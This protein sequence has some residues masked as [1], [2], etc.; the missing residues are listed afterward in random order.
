MSPS[1]RNKVLIGA[2]SILGLVIVALLLVPA[3]VDLNGRKAELAAEVKKATGRDLVID[4]P[5]SLSIL[6]SPSVSATGVKFFN[7]PGAKNPNMVEVRSVI[8]RPSVLALLAGRLE[9][10]EVV[11]DQ[12]KIV[13]EVNAEG[14]PNWEF[15]PSVAEAKPVASKPSS[16][17]PLSLGTLAIRDGTLIFS[18]AQQGISVVAEKANLSASVGS[19]DGPYSAAGSATING[20]PLSFDVG[21]GA[22]GGEGYPARI[23]VSTPDGKLSFDGRLSELGP[24]ARLSGAANV[25]ASSLSGFT[26]TLVGLAGRKPLALP[27]LLSGKFSFEGGIDVSQGGF[28]AKDFKIALGNDSGSGSLSIA[29]KPTLAVEATL[30]VPR[31]D[32]D[33]WLAALSQ[34]SAPTA[35]PAA[36]SD[37]APKPA[38]GSAAAAPAAPPQ[39]SLFAVANAKVAIDAGEVLY[40]KQAVRNVSLQLE[41]RGGVVAVPKLSAALP[42]DAVLEAKST[43]SG[44]PARPSASGEFSLVAPKLRETLQWLAVD[45]AALPSGKFTRLSIKGRM[46]SSRGDVQVP[47]ATV[48]LD[49]MNATGGLTV[50]F[51]VPLSIATRIELDTL[52]LDSLLAGA[53]DGKTGTSSAPAPQSASAAPSTKRQAVAGPLLE[54][55]AKVGRLIYNKQTATG[56]EVDAALQGET[57]KLNDLK[58]ANFATARFAV[59]GTVA[60]FRSELPR[61]DIAFNFD[62][63]NMTQFLKAVGSTAPDEL[64]HVAMSGGVAGTIE[65][66]TIKD[67]SVSAM[68]ESAKASGTLSMPGAAGG[69]PQA[70][71][72]K[73]SVTFNGQTIEGSVDA[74]LEGRPQ[75]TA[76]LRTSLLDLDKLSAGS[77]SARP[78]TPARGAAS[79]KPV[80]KTIDTSAL[81]GVDGS[82]KLVAATFVSA[83]LRLNNVT[84]V[85]SLKDGVL[86]LSQ[87]KGGLFGGTLELAGTV[88][89][90]QPALAF[91]IKGDANS[92]YLG[93]MLR[94]MA[95]TNIFGGT[96]KITVDGRLN[97]NGIA[98][99]GSGATPEQLKSSMAG[100][101]QL[102]GHVYAGADKALTTLGTAATGVVGGV[103]DNT[104]GNALGIIGHTAG[105][106]V[107]N[108]L[109]AASL[110]LNR[111]V[112]RDNPISGRVDIAGGILTD[113]GLAVQGDRATANIA[114][115]TD[116]IHSSTNTTVNFVIAE[117]PSAPYVIVSLRGALSSPSFSVSRGTAKDP[118]GFVNTLEQGVTAP[119]RQ[120]LPNVPIP[121]IP[122]PNI[123]GR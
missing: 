52:D 6:P 100:G 61:P 84:I 55:K 66:L 45:V 101:A 111:F 1:T 96:I 31:L 10:S 72:Y 75:I 80:D 71:G 15:A 28:A 8:V 4:G 11:L 26:T 37:N 93:E 115:R 2:G 23:A 44:D 121:N 19:L 12:P 5:I 22:K 106:G 73:G 36:A 105:V 7:M 56:V 40:N 92:I 95:G 33:A 48:E 67:F 118:P 87:F 34:P 62:A 108:M 97:A 38:G 83:P 16:P 9:V 39:E 24:A 79:A 29:L 91:D 81:R 42:G 58:V 116:L 120:I 110:L 59:R 43:L 21:I 18:D 46:T 50:T 82:L 53:G 117:D 60:D 70:V 27:P 3:F 112:N 17:R 122:I 35:T 65:Q 64:G 102:S 104:L 109:N 88:N 74:K 119:A 51:G 113:K 69:K 13:L 14:K 32:L 103:I 114:T 77:G 63:D 49:G 89:A 78:S 20:A 98:I 86:T 99:R 94:S 57:L 107:S 68:G 76:D 90:T 123:F 41:S 30:S 54:L 25:S 47:D 85:A